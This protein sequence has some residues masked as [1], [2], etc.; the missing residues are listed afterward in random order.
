MMPFGDILFCREYLKC[1]VGTSTIPQI[2]RLDER[3]LFLE[4]SERW[5]AL[6][7]RYNMPRPGHGVYN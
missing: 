7:L 3:G 2:S 1:K 6:H 5:D 4:E